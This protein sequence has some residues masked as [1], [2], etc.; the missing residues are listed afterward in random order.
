MQSK[1]KLVLK[2]FLS[3]FNISGE[4]LEHRANNNLE[5]SWYNVGVFYRRAL[6]INAD[7]KGL[8]N[9]F[10]SRDLETM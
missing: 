8:N 3:T 7:R 9:R 5:A 4:D 2:G 1:K 10:S 6:G